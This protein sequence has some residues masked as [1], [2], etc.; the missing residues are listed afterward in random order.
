MHG[1]EYFYFKTRVLMINYTPQNQ[2]SFSLFKHPFESELDKKNRWVKL[3]AVVPLDK[4]VSIYSLKLQSDI[5]RLSVDI[6]IV[7]AALI[8][9]HI[10]CLDDRGTIKM[11]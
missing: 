3:V 11:I 7:I 2:I 6:F 8:I 1:V 4:L 10:L 5:A 9:K